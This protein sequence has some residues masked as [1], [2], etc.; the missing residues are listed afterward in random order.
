MRVLGELTSED[1]SLKIPDSLCSP[2]RRLVGSAAD[3]ML[4]TCG[5]AL[6][7]RAT[8]EA[9]TAIV[10]NPKDARVQAMPHAALSTFRPG[11]VIIRID[12][13]QAKQGAMPP[14]IRAMY[15][16]AADRNSPLAFVCAGSACSRPSTTADEVR[17]TLEQFLVADLSRTI[18]LPASGREPATSSP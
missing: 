13:A 9:T 2:P 14:P 17:A 1:R 8:G 16:A 6:N 4:E 18:A 12:P 7:E 3:S 5:F 15:E 11:K 10:G